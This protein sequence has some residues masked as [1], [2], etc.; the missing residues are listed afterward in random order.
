MDV[1]ITMAFGDFAAEEV[2][3]FDALIE[4]VGVAFP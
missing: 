2:V 3:D 1:A 4:E